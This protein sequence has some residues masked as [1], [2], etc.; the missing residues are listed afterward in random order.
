MIGSLSL[1]LTVLVSAAGEDA[2]KEPDGY[3]RAEPKDVEFRLE[4]V[5]PS[6]LPFQAVR[7]RAT[8]KNVSAKRVGP[9]RPMDGLYDILV[10]GPRESSFREVERAVSILQKGLPMNP[11]HREGKN[12][13]ALMCLDP[14]EE[15]SATF[16]VAA[17]WRDEVKP[18]FPSPGKYTLKLVYQTEHRDQQRIDQTVTVEVREPESDDDKAVYRW[19]REDPEL[20]AE[21]LC[22]VGRPAEGTVPTIKREVLGKRP[23]SSYAPYARFALGRHYRYRDWNGPRREEFRA[24]A[25][26]LLEKAGR[27]DFPYRPNALIALRGLAPGAKQQADPILKERFADAVEWQEVVASSFGLSPEQWEAFRKRGAPGKPPTKTARPPRPTGPGEIDPKTLKKV[28][29]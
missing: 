8:L 27:A 4:V 28:R 17:H 29:P 1:A 22:P 19:L 24:T 3:V 9:M 12:S 2:P 15:T 5:G 13:T 18:V 20:A 21:L 6:P 14:G 25:A 7:L 16:A 10:R 26:G 11:T 23:D